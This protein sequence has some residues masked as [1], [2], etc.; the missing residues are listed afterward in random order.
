MPEF[1]KPLLTAGG[2]I[3]HGHCYLWNPDLVWLHVVSDSLIA[4]AYYSIPFMLVYFVRKRRDVPFDWIFLMFSSFIVACGTTHLLEVWTL[5]HPIYWLSGFVKAFTA[6]VSLAT[7]VLLGQLM[8]KALILPSPVQLEAANLALKNEITQRKLAEEALYRREQ[9]FKA[10]VENTPDV[11]TRYDRELRSLYVNPAM[12]WE[13][14]IAPQAFIGK[15]LLETGFPEE[16]AQLWQSWF[17]EVFATGEMSLKEFNY[18]GPKGLKFY[19]ARIVPEFAVNGSVE[20]VF[21]VV[22]DIT[23]LKQAEE[24]LKRANEELEIRVTE[25][26]AEFAKINECLQ[27]EIAERKRVEEAL[28]RRGRQLEILS[29]TS[30]QINAVLE[31]PAVMRTLIASAIELVGVTAGTYGMMSQGKM[32]FTEYNENGNVRPIA[33]TFERGIGVPGWVMETLQPYVAND[34]EHDSHVLPHLQKAFGFYNLVN[35]P[36]FNRKGEL[37]GC[38]ELH[39]KAERRPFSDNDIT[40]LQGLANSAAVALENS[41]MLV[42]RQQVEEALRLSEQRFR[43]IF[44]QAAVG[45]AQVGL[46]GQWLLVNQKLCDIV[47][48]TREELLERSFQDITYPDDLAADLAYV[49]QILAGEIETYSIEKRYIRKDGYH[50]W[51]NLNVSLVSNS[52]GE[53]QYF[54]AVIKD[55]SDRK[56]TEAE[57]RQSLKDLSDLKFALDQAALVA[58][59]DT[60]GVITYVNDKFC[61]LSQYSREELIGQTHRLINSDYHPQDFFKEIW[62]TITAGKVWQGEIKNRAKDGRYYWVDSAIVPF[63]NEQGQPFQYL[64]I[65]FDI[66]GR[67]QAEEM[68]QLTQFSVEQASDSIFWL[69]SDARI[70]RV[71][72]AACQLLGYTEQE[73][74]S[75]SVHDIDP[76]YQAEVWPAHWQELKERGSMTFESRHKAKDGTITPTEVNVNFLEFGGKEYNLAF[77]RDIT[78]RKRAETALKSLVAGTAAVTGDEFFSALVQHLAAALG[79]RYA[80]VTEGVGEPIGKARTLAFWAGDKLGENFEYDIAN[81]PCEIV[82][83]HKKIC[84]YPD[85]VQALFPQDLDLVAMQAVC[86][87]GVP[88]FDT[89]QQLIGLLC[90]LDD[91]P[92]AEEQRAQSILSI[93][94]ARAAAELER[95]RTEEGL[96]QSEERLR[97]ALRATRLGTWD[98]NVLSKTLTWSDNV[99]SIF[100]LAPGSFKGTYE[101]FLECIHPE[102]RDFVAQLLVQAFEQRQTSE[103]ENE[104]RIVCPDGTIRWLSSSGQYFY[105]ET[106]QLIRMLGTCWDITERKRVEQEIRELN[107]QLERRVVERTA[108]LEA[109][110]K[111]L[112]AFSYSVSHDLRAPLRHIDGFSKALLERYADNLDDKGKHYLQRI[113]VGTQRM[114]ELIDD[115]LTLSRMT[116]SEMHRTKV[117]LSAIALNIATELSQT[118]PERKVEFAIAPGLIA[119]GDARLLRVVLENLL[120]NA[121]KF[122]SNRVDS[123]IEFGVI[124]HEEA[125]IVYFLRD[126]GAGFDMTYANKLFGAFQRLHTAAQFP[127]T[128]IGLATVQRIIHRHGGRV[129]AEGAVEQ[130]ATFYFTL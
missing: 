84:C 44:N 75:L 89:S 24:T 6:L 67:K 28:L 10:L 11:I 31:I 16:L 21:T 32:V 3:P 120:N 41:Q 54:I 40:M 2:F 108:Q 83:N 25:R 68:L 77:A 57:L 96:Q 118:Q 35:L 101:A 18:L 49:R 59:T 110:N 117:D 123:Q 70:L 107:E 62:S 112:E 8:P 127:G 53:P 113:R 56:I 66:T 116:R 79:V 130:G 34:A 47:G 92:L 103:W 64:A 85:G 122:T 111:E 19:Q 7:A 20:S 129:W 5:W 43:A 13:T 81:T 72:K 37:L 23:K 36:I 9:E 109:A 12:E 38:F 97:L 88:L 128:G 104:Y 22:R 65:R 102:D 114:G 125:K 27:A 121:W 39:N 86:Y 99:E 60:R 1:F 26:T 106:D 58:I 126:N 87:L 33:E 42:E 69:G 115:L 71:N 14:G 94:A 52:S 46:D 95:K 61:E 90:V 76:D 78:D 80:L 100:G 63:L 29:S 55:I 45:I 119:D 30:R 74:L 124:L 51:I 98:W 91:K 48:Y 4:L 50:V 93:F 15:T 73:L 82:T 17:K 105:N